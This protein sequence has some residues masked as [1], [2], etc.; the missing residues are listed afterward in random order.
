VIS[1]GL[2]RFSGRFQAISRSL[3]LRFPSFLFGLPPYA[4]AFQ[5]SF[6]VCPSYDSAFRTS[7]SV[8]PS[9][10]SV[11]PRSFCLYTL[12]VS[13]FPRSWG[14]FGLFSITLRLFLGG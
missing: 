7:F 12:Y 13:D 14:T 2:H 4:F 3:R 8:C 11:C 5:A 9:Y 10:A 1:F 6:S